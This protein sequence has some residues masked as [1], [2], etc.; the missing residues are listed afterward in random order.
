MD[1]RT[2]ALEQEVGRLK[3]L[4]KHHEIDEEDAP[5][6]LVEQHDSANNEGLPQDHFPS[7]DY[8]PS[9]EGLADA[10]IARNHSTGSERNNKTTEASA[11]VVISAVSGP[12]ENDNDTL[13]NA[14]NP[15]P[16]PPITNFRLPRELRDHVY[17]Y[18]LDGEN[19]AYVP[20]HGE[21]THSTDYNNHHGESHAY[22]FHLEILR[23]NKTIGKEASE[24]FQK[25]NQFVLV[26]YRTHHPL[27]FT[28]PMQAFNV[29]IVKEFGGARPKI[30]AFAVGIHWKHMSAGLRV[31]DEPEQ[32][33]YLMLLRDLHHLWK[34][35][36]FQ[37]LFT[38][39][40][41]LFLGTSRGLSM[42]SFLTSKDDKSTCQLVVQKTL[43]REACSSDQIEAKFLR[44]LGDA[45]GAG[46]LL[47]MLGF[48]DSNIV[49]KIK[50]KITPSLPSL[51]AVSWNRLSFMAELKWA[52]DDCMR[53]GRYQAAEVRYRTV[54]SY[55]NSRAYNLHMR[56]VKDEDK[57]RKSAITH[58]AVLHCDLICSLVWCHLYLKDF[59]D[60]LERY[61]KAFDLI[62]EQV[63]RLKHVA[64]K[65]HHLLTV[66]YFCNPR[67]PYMEGWEGQKLRDM[68]AWL[69]QYDS[70]AQHDAEVIASVL[71]EHRDSEVSGREKLPVPVEK[72]SLY[73]LPPRTFN[74]FD[75]GFSRKKD[76]TYSASLGYPGGLVGWQDTEQIQNLTAEDKALIHKYQQEHGL[77]TTD[78]DE[79]QQ[80]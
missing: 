30:H 78:F 31:G 80:S 77:L 23:V 67:L 32:G 16:P 74:V 41:T 59:G 39:P 20:E 71:A 68:V 9:T 18:L 26:S 19:T 36:R 50:K 43:P 61:A 62:R 54:L 76:G 72:L 35:L 73:A 17:A 60:Q 12:R 49:E 58:G 47:T 2:E 44:G 66:M 24:I 4:L 57:K 29:P 45:M 6:L 11:M 7:S 38:T 25:R 56:T 37:C 70:Y 15:S 14:A 34:L 40:K 42:D 27:Y 63:G 13:A 69:K 53:R 10:D 64:S 46:Y 1:K 51:L 79:L 33:A 8:S 5:A 65:I 3:A 22:K 52:A 28:I 75:D 55:F 21:A 48:Q